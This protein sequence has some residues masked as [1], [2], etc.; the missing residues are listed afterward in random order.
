MLLGAIGS[1]T[2]QRSYTMLQCTTDNVAEASFQLGAKPTQKRMTFNEGECTT[3]MRY[4]E[5]VSH[6]TLL[7]C[8]LLAL[9]MEQLLMLELEALA[10]MRS[11]S[12]CGGVIDC[13]YFAAPAKKV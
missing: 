10:K 5:T 2:T 9:H 11:L 1:W 13:L 8:A 6:K 7:P 3:S 4:I 12:P